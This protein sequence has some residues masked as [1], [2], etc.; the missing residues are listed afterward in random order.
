MAGKH[1]D[2]GAQRFD[3]KRKFIAWGVF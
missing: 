1:G 2:E 3:T